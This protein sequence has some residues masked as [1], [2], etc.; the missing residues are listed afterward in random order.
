MDTQ[1]RRRQLMDIVRDVERTYELSQSD[2]IKM[3]R[4]ELQEVQRALQAMIERAFSPR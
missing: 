2:A 4:S 3:V 1:S